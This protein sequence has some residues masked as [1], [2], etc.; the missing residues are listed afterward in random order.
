MND[1]S[2]YL[3][4]QREEVGEVHVIITDLAISFI[5]ITLGG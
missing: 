1:I 3:G 5:L 4:R 2:V